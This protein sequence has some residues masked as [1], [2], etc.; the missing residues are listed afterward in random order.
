MNKAFAKIPWSSSDGFVV[1]VVPQV[2]ALA[3]IRLDELIY[4]KN[5]DLVHV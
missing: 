3:R 1:V 2:G 5:Q 4:F